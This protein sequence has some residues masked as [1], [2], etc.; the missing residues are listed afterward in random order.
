MSTDTIF[1]G[2]CT[3]IAAA[4]SS[5]PI[6]YSGMVFTP[7]ASGLW[8]EVKPFY[9]GVTE[10]GLTNPAVER[11]FLR[12]MVCGRRGAGSIAALKLAEQVAAAF[13]KGTIFGGARQ[14]ER[15]SLSSVIEDGDKIIVPVTVSWR[16]T[17]VS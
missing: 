11:G 12:V 13:P 14:D 9:S 17:R 7:P 4:F 8:L 10:Y 5:Y 15:P 1:S 3:K 16:A 6:A 2:F